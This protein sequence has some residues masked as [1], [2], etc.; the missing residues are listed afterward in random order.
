MRWNLI[1]EQESRAPATGFSW[2]ELQRR[3]EEG[4]EH[5]ITLLLMVR[6]N[7][8]EAGVHSWFALLAAEQPPGRRAATASGSASTHC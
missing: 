7:K 8:G 5:S 6:A 3:D 4:I 1:G 2:L